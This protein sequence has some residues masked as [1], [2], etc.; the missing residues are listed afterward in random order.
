MTKRKEE[1]QAFFDESVTHN[2]GQV[3]PKDEAEFV[4]QCLEGLANMVRND[5]VHGFSWSW[6]QGDGMVD[7]VNII[8]PKTPIK[9][10]TIKI[11]LENPK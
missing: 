6:N 7:A 8:K 11:N 10:I 3:R 9:M 5:W 4:A 1:A 2:L